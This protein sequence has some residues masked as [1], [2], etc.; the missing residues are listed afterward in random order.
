[1]KKMNIYIAR[2][3]ESIS[4]AGG[5]IAYP[6]TGLTV[7][8]LKDAL[9]FGMRFAEGEIKIDAIYCSNLFRALQTLDKFLENYKLTN[10]NKIFVTDLLN[11]INRFDYSGRPSTEYYADRDASGKDPAA[12]KS[13]LGESENEVKNRA[14]KFKQLIE[15]NS[16][17]NILII[18]HGHLLHHLCD[19][20]N[21]PS[22]GHL[23]GATF[24]L[25]E[26]T[27]S[28]SKIV[29]WNDSSHIKDQ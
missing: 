7:K 19:L 16:Y 17:K 21:V 6:Y 24:T 27:D 5:Y 14:I 8:G 3:G 25:L 11:E 23:S 1:M 15:K 28:K 10:P 4:N 20:Y 26:L 2:H 12:F 22:L 29:T 13:L 9:S 18:S